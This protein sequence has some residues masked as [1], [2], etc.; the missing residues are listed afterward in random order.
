M[1]DCNE[2]KKE[3]RHE[4]ANLGKV[5]QLE[6]WWQLYITSLLEWDVRNFRQLDFCW[7][8]CTPIIVIFPTC[9]LETGHQ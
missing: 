5:K 9:G 6:L 2:W 3:K 8:E 7:T 1:T 4:C